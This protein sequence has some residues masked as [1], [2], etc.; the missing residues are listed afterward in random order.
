MAGTSKFIPGRTLNTIP[1]FNSANSVPNKLFFHTFKINA[2][3]TN[4]FKLMSKKSSR[5]SRRLISISTAD[6]RWHGK[7]NSDYL[8]SL[9][10]LHLED[11]IEDDHD[12][13]A[14]VS[15]SLCIQKHASFGF[16]VEGRIIT[17]FTRKCCICFSPYCR[18]VDT[19]FS[20]WV[21]QSSRNNRALQLPEIGGDDPSLSH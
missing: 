21:L 16:S 9:K 7:W 3:R 19:N 6:G 13:D 20:V 15:V 5:T 11:L 14:K 18:K 1:R 17:S 8:L 4:D 2:S 10:D 12:K